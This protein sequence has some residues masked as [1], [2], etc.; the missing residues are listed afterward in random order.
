MTAAAKRP[1][2]TP[3]W[4]PINTAPDGV[5]VRTK[6]DDKNGV[7]NTQLLKRRGRLWFTSDGIMYVYYTPTHWIPA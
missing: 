2:L 5:L 1:D 3:D 6:I 4:Q 7:R